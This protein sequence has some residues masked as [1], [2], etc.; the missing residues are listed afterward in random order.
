MKFS[1]T[2][3]LARDDL[4][5]SKR[6][7]A[8]LLGDMVY[9]EQAIEFARAM[10]TKVGRK[11][12]GTISASAL[13]GC[14]RYQQFVFAG[15]SKIPPDAKGMMKMSNGSF[16]HLRWQMAGLTE[17]WLSEAEVWMDSPTYHVVGT[18]DGILFDE[19][20]L[21]LKSINVNGF[22]NVQTFG[23]LHDHLFQ[24]ATYMLGTGKTEGVF[25]YECKDNQEYL[26]IPVHA[27]DLPLD[28][29]A[30][31]AAAIWV[32]SGEQ[33]LFEPLDKCLDRTGWVYE[34][35]PFR[36]RCLHIHTWDQVA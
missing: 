5:V 26:E 25:I 19:R 22:R 18:M 6:H 20:I 23:P 35:C 24:M 16:M 14:A 9:S 1:Q 17:G 32:A 36:D 27:A 33:R 12:L 2:V 13:G 34:S 10:L 15:M 4:V 29:A 3:K 21:E 31:K 7:D 8:W 30:E 11:R 28:A